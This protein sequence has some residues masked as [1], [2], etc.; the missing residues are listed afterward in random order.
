MQGEGQDKA[1]NKELEYIEKDNMPY[2]T[3]IEVQG[4]LPLRQRGTGGNRPYRIPVSCWVKT[5]RQT[6]TRNATIDYKLT[7]KFNRFANDADWHIEY[8]EENPDILV[9]EPYY[10]SYL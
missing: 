4:V 6:T 5:P 7:L 9:P 1:Q 3:Y 10:I 8:E 2:G